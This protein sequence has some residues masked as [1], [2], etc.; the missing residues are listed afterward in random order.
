MLA[1]NFVEVAIECCGICG[2]DI[3]TIDSGQ[4]VRGECDRRVQEENETRKQASAVE[5]HRAG[6]RDE[7]LAL[8]PPVLM[9]LRSPGWVLRCLC[10][11][12]GWYQA[13]YPLIVGHEIVGTV[14]SVGSEVKNVRVGDRVGIG[15]QCGSCL[16]GS[17]PQKCFECTEGKVQHC[18]VER[19]LTYG[20]QR[21]DGQ[22]T[23]GGYA[24][25]IR[26]A[27][28]FAVPIPAEISSAEAAPLL[29]AGITVYAPLS[30]FLT[31]PGMRV[32]VI[33][34]GGL[35][36]LAL[37]FASKMQ[38]GSAIVTAISH[39]ARKREES[40]KLGATKFL[41]TSS[42]KVSAAPSDPALPFSR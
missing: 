8:P 21:P 14:T 19:T 33:G 32:G 36:H 2:S 42:G 12:A 31:R 26:C 29:C 22:V 16:D 17:A 24:D 23:Q 20:T 38:D 41:D 6:R 5:V 10:V 4:C 9:P 25:R 7:R 3:H 37:Q 18:S 28:S 34:I 35:G 13:K 30:R 15:A 27:S 1:P 11:C 40:M 39:N